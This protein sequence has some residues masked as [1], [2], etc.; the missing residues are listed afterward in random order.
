MSELRL[1]Y[2]SARLGFEYAAS[3]RVPV[4]SSGPATTPSNDCA[5]QVDGT[6]KCDSPRAATLDCRRR[7]CREHV[8][9]TPGVRKPSAD[10]VGTRQLPDFRRPPRVPFDGRSGVFEPVRPVAAGLRRRLVPSP[11]PTAAERRG[12]R[13]AVPGVRGLRGVARVVSA[14]AGAFANRCSC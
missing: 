9:L 2:T 1:R 13:F 14:D 11:V 3:K 10:A 5:A 7:S 8:S 6:A 4:E 12:L